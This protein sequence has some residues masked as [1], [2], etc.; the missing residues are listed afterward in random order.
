MQTCSTGA[1]RRLASPPSLD[2]V[3][4][5]ERRAP[6]P[7]TTR[8]SSTALFGRPPAGGSPVR[9]RATR[10]RATAVRTPP[11]SSGCWA[12]TLRFRIGVDDGEHR[13]CVEQVRRREDQL[14]AAAL[15]VD[16]H[17]L[18]VGGIALEVVPPD[19]DPGAARQP[20]PGATTEP[21][22]DS[23]RPDV[24]VDELETAPP[25]SARIT[26]RSW[27]TLP[28]RTSAYT[29]AQPRR[30]ARRAPRSSAPASSAA[31]C[32]TIAGS[33]D[34]RRAAAARRARA[35]GP[36]GGCEHRDLDRA[37]SEG[38]LG[39]HRRRRARPPGRSTF[40]YPSW[41]SRVRWPPAHRPRRTG[42]RERLLAEDREPRAGRR[43]PR[44]RR[45][46]PPVRIATASSPLG[47]EQRA[48]PARNRRSAPGPRSGR[49]RASRV[50]R[51]RSQSA[52][53][54][55]RAGCFESTGRCTACA[56]TPKPTTP[57]R[58]GEL[59]FAPTSGA[60]FA[61]LE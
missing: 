54:T 19:R 18:P 1:G 42:V 12:I 47:G 26:A 40:M 53:T 6:R 44:A 56:T 41:S 20:T 28:S 25:A 34:P 15:V 14:D 48:R 31:S 60:T 7:D 46:S 49:R 27:T 2:V 52:L 24:G 13:R 57:T 3:P 30:R 43:S 16:A 58:T 5:R 37:R 35:A 50:P 39:Q 29:R 21:S 51:D 61:R 4:R 11:R 9:A 45:G 17:L 36:D 38:R 33:E 32:A 55:K 10:T 8:T 59:A 22:A 23:C